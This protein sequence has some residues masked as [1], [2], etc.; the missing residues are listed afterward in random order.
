MC[1]DGHLGFLIAL[2]QTIY[3]YGGTLYDSSSINCRFWEISNRL[4]LLRWHSSVNILC[5][6]NIGKNTYLYFT[7][8]TD[9]GLPNTITYISRE[10][11]QCQ[12]CFSAIFFFHKI[13]VFICC[14]G[15]SSLHCL[16]LP[17]TLYLKY[18]H[19][20]LSKIYFCLKSRMLDPIFLLTPQV[21]WSPS[22][23]PTFFHSKL[24]NLRMW[25]TYVFYH[26][27]ILPLHCFLSDTKQ[28]LLT[29]LQIKNFYQFL[30]S[31]PD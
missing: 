30:C 17:K 7:W 23:F 14:R 22:T 25:N 19:L 9:N 8:W 1:N 2:I 3:I 4:F 15:T 6:S 10:S 5:S 16:I 13:K 29:T 20:L 26:V 21:H 28:W 27:C 31:I 12:P 24:R 11:Y 18:P